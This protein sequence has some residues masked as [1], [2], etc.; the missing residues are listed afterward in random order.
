MMSFT[1]NQTAAF[2]LILMTINNIGVTLI[3]KA[4]FAMIRFPYPYMLTVIHMAINWLSCEYIFYTI[5]R[6]KT[7]NTKN[8]WI[9]LLGS[10]D[11]LLQS[12]SSPSSTNNSVMVMLFYSILFSMNIAIGNVSLQHVSINFNQVMRSLVPILTLGCSWYILNQRN[13][14]IQ[15]RVAVW[16]V[17]IGVAISAI[18]DRMSVTVAGFIYTLLCVVLAAVKVVA[19][20]E[21]LTG[22]SATIT[23]MHPLRLLQQMAPHALVQCLFLSIVTGEF[24]TIRQRWYIDIDPVSTGNFT[25]ITI[26]IISGILAFSLNI[27][28]LQAYKVTSPLTCCIAAAVKQV[29]MVLIGTYMF[30]TPITPLN[31]F[32]IAVVLIA[33]TYYSY[34]SINEP[35]IISPNGGNN[36][37][38]Q[39][40]DDDNNDNILDNDVENVSSS[41]KFVGEQVENSLDDEN[42]EGNT[43]LLQRS[44]TS[45]ERLNVVAQR[46]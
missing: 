8:I 2:W 42:F 25:P 6:S 24:Y 12:P 1:N 33:S 26:L 27:S 13:V 23:K 10:S 19:S 32:G 14:S 36:N 30:N 16:P 18:G 45:N 20:S 37:T 7:N 28:A 11:D 40:D 9:Q 39:N 3:N 17:V 22:S 21:L 31:G 34:V 15:R 46:R 43:P 5:A 44:P 29:L 35:K 38:K 41:S 4:S